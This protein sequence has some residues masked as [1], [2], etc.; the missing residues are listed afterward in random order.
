MKAT[1]TLK[2]AKQAPAVVSATAYAGEE[3]FA[4]DGLSPQVFRLA[5]GKCDPFAKLPGAIV[6]ALLQNSPVASAP[7]VPPMP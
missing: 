4:G 7:Q 1:S 6:T 2:A 3:L 5:G